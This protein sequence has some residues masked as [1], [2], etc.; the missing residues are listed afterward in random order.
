MADTHRTHP[1]EITASDAEIMEERM[2]LYIFPN[3]PVTKEE[4]DAF[5]DAVDYQLE[6][7]RARREQMSD[8][9]EGAT[10]FRIGDFQM[11]FDSGYNTSAL[12]S[13]TIC[14]AAKSRLLRAGLL[15]RGLEGRCGHGAD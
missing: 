6:H 14:P 7:E 4:R 10:S 11:S 15:Y 8:I 3:T 13:K 1:C 9:P 2:L 5:D 12:S